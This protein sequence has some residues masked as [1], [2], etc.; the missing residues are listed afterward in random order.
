MHTKEDDTISQCEPA[1]AR[2]D[3]VKPAASDAYMP[4]PTALEAIELNLQ[5]SLRV[6]TDHHFFAWTQ[7][8][9]QNLIRH[10]LLICVLRNDDNKLCQVD[11]FS[12]AQT[13]QK[14]F[15]RLYR[16][17]ASLAEKIV[18][19]WETN[20]FQPVV[21]DAEK[22][23]LIADTA[24]GRALNRIGANA[25]IVHGTY[26]SH[27]KMVSLFLFACRAKDTDPG[28]ARRVEM[29]VPF[30]HA[31]WV[32]TKV[33]L[34]AK[35]GEG[36]AHPSERDLLTQRELEVLR[37]VCQGKSNIEIGIILGISPLTVKNHVQGI[38]RRLNV[39]NR[40]QAVGKAINLNILKY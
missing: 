18:K 2:I 34:S 37:W 24:L 13:D 5:A 3:A 16:E 30:L 26:D 32:R 19:V 25:V 31:A 22:D 29:L 28:Q 8:L 38:L 27:A 23:A 21:L 6:Y 35:A 36:N 4:D 7:G 20:H 15:S 10:E 33:S 12:S 14:L 40:T 1:G 39:Q 9:L 17:D 11:S